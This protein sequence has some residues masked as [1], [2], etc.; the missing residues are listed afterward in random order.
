[1]SCPVMSSHVVSMSHLTHSTL[2]LLE[3][4][5]CDKLDRCILTARCRDP[6]C[7]I[8]D[9]SRTPIPSVFCLRQRNTRKKHVD[10]RALQHT[11][12]HAH[13]HTRT[14]AR[15]L[16]H[17]SRRWSRLSGRLLPWPLRINTLQMR[18][19]QHSNI[20]AHRHTNPHPPSCMNL[21]G[22][23]GFADDVFLG[24]HG[25]STS[26]W[27]HSNICMHTYTLMHMHTC[28]HTLTHPHA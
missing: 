3:I 17:K 6:F 12:T 22:D 20:H 19:F 13:G 24:L 9:G 28:T 26:T 8:P 15:P 23:L 11:F 18:A 21:A 27:M 25:G 2:S 10:M 14:R 4:G 5:K 7:R 16:V 1:M